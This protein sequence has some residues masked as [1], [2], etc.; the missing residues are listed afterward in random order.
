VSR[1]RA[2]RRESVR[3]ATPLERRHAA[4]LDAAPRPSRLR[5]RGEPSFGEGSDVA[6]Q[7]LHAV[8]ALEL[9]R[10]HEAV[11]VEILKDGDL[12]PRVRHLDPER[13][14]RLRVRG[15]GRGRFRP[16]VAPAASTGLPWSDGVCGT[17]WLDTACRS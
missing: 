11:P 8:E 5:L 10:V 16:A 4:A 14:V 7:R 15:A 13:Q 1:A 9:A 3:D 2:D 6:G 17:R 12:P